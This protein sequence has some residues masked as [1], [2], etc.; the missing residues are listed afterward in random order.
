MSFFI[1]LKAYKLTK[2]HQKDAFY[3]KTRLKLIL[4][5]FPL[6]I[7]LCAIIKKYLDF[8]NHSIYLIGALLAIVSI[9]L[10]SQWLTKKK[11]EEQ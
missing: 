1:R 5:I 2:E 6:V 9:N 10:G 3:N 11:F 4:I 7:G 8:D